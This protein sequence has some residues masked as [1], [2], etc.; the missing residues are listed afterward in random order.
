MSYSFTVGQI[1][2]YFNSIINVL[3]NIEIKYK[4]KFKFEDNKKIE[5]IIDKRLNNEID[6]VICKIFYNDKK[7]YYEVLNAITELLNKNRKEKSLT[8]HTKNSLV[9]K[10]NFM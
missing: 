4:D 5:V 6:G 7:H 10:I 1:K 8:N 2:K 9:C 3:N